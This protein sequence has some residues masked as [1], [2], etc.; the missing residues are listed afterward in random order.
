MAVLGKCSKA[1]VIPQRV[2]SQTENRVSTSG[3]WSSQPIKSSF[4]QE[5]CSSVGLYN[6]RNCIRQAVGN[7]NQGAT[8]NVSEQ[9]I[10][11]TLHRKGYGGR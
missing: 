5:S 10:R 11:L 1:P 6:F 2:D 9:N 7:L 3:L 8:A 4:E